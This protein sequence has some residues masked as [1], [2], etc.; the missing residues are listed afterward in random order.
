MLE[1][2]ILNMFSR[3]KGKIIY[4]YKWKLGNLN[5][6]IEQ[7]INM[8]LSIHINIKELMLLNCGVGEDSWE[9]LRLQGDPTSPS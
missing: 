1:I 2:A 3:T 9:S 4:L 7:Y 5:K 8:F 6:V